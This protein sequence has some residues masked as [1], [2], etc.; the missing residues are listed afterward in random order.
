[1]G[2]QQK[3]DWNEQGR[4]RALKKWLLHVPGASHRASGLV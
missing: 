2:K 4:G 1:M 3:H